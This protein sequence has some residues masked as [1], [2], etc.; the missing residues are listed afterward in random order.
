MTRIRKLEE[1]E[2]KKE[3]KGLPDFKS[4][5]TGDKWKKCGDNDK[6]MEYDNILDIGSSEF[7]AWNDGDTYAF[8]FSTIIQYK[9]E[10]D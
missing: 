8:V 3:E 1:L 7:V 6:S 4:I 2:L 5:L 10:N 9:K